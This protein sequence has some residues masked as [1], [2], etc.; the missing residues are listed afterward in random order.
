[1]NIAMRITNITL[2]ITIMYTYCVLI[3]NVYKNQKIKIKDKLLVGVVAIIASIVMEFSSLY[4]NYLLYIVEFIS[5][6]FIFKVILKSSTSYTLISITIIF[7][8]H[9]LS[10]MLVILSIKLYNTTQISTIS[11]STNH[12]YESTFLML[13]YILLI[14]F[15]IEELIERNREK[16]YNIVESLEFKNITLIIGLV[17]LMITPI[18][19]RFYFNQNEQSANILLYGIVQFLSTS[20]LIFLFVKYIIYYS[21]TNSKLKQVTLYNQTLNELVDSMRLLKHDYNNILQSINGYIATK[22]YN[23]LENHMSSLIKDA[24]KM[25][26]T[27]S[28]NPNIINQPAIYGI[29]GTKYYLA[30]RKNID[31]KID[32]TKDIKSINFD[33]TKLSRILGILLDNAIEAADKTEERKISISFSHSKRKNADIIEIKNS[34]KDGKSIDVDAIFNKGV[35]SKKVKSGLGLWEVQKIISKTK[36]SQIFADVKDNT[37]SQTIVIENV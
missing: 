19:I 15:T 37:F 11:I 4:C 36:N 13:D 17:L 30:G 25:S 31:F 29:V 2:F 32:V 12:F 23:E 18:V 10:E 1:M 5:L 3:T 27:E 24:T 28:I 21:K 9:T 20:L 22:Q 26:V 6:F 33:F 35:S 7:I 16:I 14:F 8:V 34:V